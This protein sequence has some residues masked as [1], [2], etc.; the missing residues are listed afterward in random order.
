MTGQADALRS[1]A[2]LLRSGIPARAALWQWHVD[3]PEWLRPAFTGL[4]RRLA[5]GQPTAAAVASLAGELDDARE[6]STLFKIHSELG[7]D[8]AAMVEGLANAAERRDQALRDGVAAGAGAVLSGRMV[9]A[10]PLLFLPLAP[11]A[12]APLFD[13]PGIVLL[14]LGVAFAATGI[15][16]ISRLMPKP[17]L[18]V[19]G[20]AWAADVCAAALQG[21]ASLDSVLHALAAAP[22]VD[23]ADGFTHA[24]RL[25]RL[26]C[27]WRTAL[28]RS[29]DDAL[30]ALGRCIATAELMGESPGRPLT[31]LAEQ[32][33]AEQSTRFDQRMRR[34]PVQMV[35]PLATCVLP[36]FLLLAVAPFARG[37]SGMV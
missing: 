27:P 20:A 36:S 17:E 26:G 14:S 11:A 23:L 22:P 18:Q 29:K 32:R 31:A 3:A 15:Y 2:A 35:V 1:L 9:A 16:W 10:L 4:A 33:R 7:G 5:L 19:D 13:K 8:A 6:L 25:V 12:R 30:A 37:L 34:A 28:G 24:R 21:G